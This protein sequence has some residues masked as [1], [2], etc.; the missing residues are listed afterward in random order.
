MVSPDPL[1]SRAVD[2]LRITIWWSEFRELNL[3]ASDGL[4]Q[5]FPLLRVRL[6]F[7]EEQLYLIVAK[8]PDYEEFKTLVED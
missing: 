5:R 6:A 7:L 3:M 4:L 2:D 1:T 8:D